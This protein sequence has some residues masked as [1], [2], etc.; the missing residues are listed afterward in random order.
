[1]H[2][3]FYLTYTELSQEEINQAFLHACAFD[4]IKAARHLL[5][6]SEPPFNAQ[7]DKVKNGAF[8]VSNLNNNE[9]SLHFLIMEM[10]IKKDYEIESFLEFRKNPYAESLFLER[11]MPK[12]EKKDTR[13]K[14]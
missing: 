12:R 1:M 8:K 10:N 11:D 5:F 9:A 7:W 14:I 3:E 13:L 4:N 6:S 2:T